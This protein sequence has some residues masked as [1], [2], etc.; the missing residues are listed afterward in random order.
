M[1]YLQL[2]RDLLLLNT[3]YV[4]M[5]L[6]IK[7]ICKEKNTTLKAVAKAIGI[8]NVNLSNSLNGNPTLSRLEEVANIL[9]VE[10]WE[11][12]KQKGKSEINGFIQFKNQVYAVTDIPTLKKIYK[13]ITEE[14]NQ[15]E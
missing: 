14:T 1:I 10:V 15:T 9:E 12:F 6:R 13:I 8:T 2:L 5:E 7:E 4:A 11:L 3:V